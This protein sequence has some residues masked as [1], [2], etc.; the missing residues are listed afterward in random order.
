MREH[1]RQETIS[2]SGWTVDT[3]KAL[4]DERDLRYGQL[5]DAKEK[6]ITAALAAAEKAVSVAELNSEKWRS[7]A[8]EWRSAM[9]DREKKFVIKDNFDTTILNLQRDVKEMKESRDRV[10]GKG[11]GLNAAWN[12]MIQVFGLL[13][14]LGMGIYIGK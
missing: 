11:A 2:P 1:S 6:A 10:E 9:D 7:N 4:M 13:A 8:N 5:S 12:L 14:A 3:L